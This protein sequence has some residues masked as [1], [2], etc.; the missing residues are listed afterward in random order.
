MML[1]NPIFISYLI[2][3]ALFLAC[4]EKAIFYRLFAHIPVSDVRQEYGIL[5]ACPLS[6]FLDRIKPIKGVILIH[7]VV[8]LGKTP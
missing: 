2:I 7:E 4:A 6:L 8:P 3:F 5:S 1:E